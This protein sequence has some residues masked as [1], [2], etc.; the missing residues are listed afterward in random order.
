MT[1]LIKIESGI[2]L[3]IKKGTCTACNS[4]ERCTIFKMNWFL[5][6]KH[7]KHLL[8]IR[9]KQYLN[10]S[11]V[12]C[13]LNKGYFLIRFL[14]NFSYSLAFLIIAF[15][16]LKYP[17]IWSIASSQTYFLFFSLLRAASTLGE[18]H[19]IKNVHFGLS[20]YCANGVSI[21]SVFTY[22]GIGFGAPFLISTNI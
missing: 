3:I 18:N 2:Y 4:I 6:E 22:T 19:G 8:M 11:F 17:T 7:H 21:S 9:N 12:P 14:P 15:F 5:D 16:D 13:W 20:R 1:N 10:H